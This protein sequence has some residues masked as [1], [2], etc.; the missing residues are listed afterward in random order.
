[1]VSTVSILGQPAPHH[2]ADCPVNI[3]SNLITYQQ[4]SLPYLWRTLFWVTH[5]SRCTL[6]TLVGMSTCTRGG[7]H[8]G[9]H[10]ITSFHLPLSHNP[11][12][13]CISSSKLETYKEFIQFSKTLDYHCLNYEIQFDIFIGF[14]G[15]SNHNTLT[16]TPLK[17]RTVNINNFYPPLYYNGTVLSTNKNT[18]NKL[19]I[20]CCFHYAGEKSFFITHTWPPKFVVL[21]YKKSKQ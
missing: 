5:P 18:Q 16:L 20:Y 6:A 4:A 3:L 9:C 17:A 10:P 21:L 2:Y 12:S 14:K 13:L 7:G 8:L 19:H 15:N 11:S 1:M